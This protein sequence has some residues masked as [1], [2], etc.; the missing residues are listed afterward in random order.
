MGWGEGTVMSVAFGGPV[1]A[2]C[3]DCGHDIVDGPAIG[4]TLRQHAGAALPIARVA[5]LCRDCFV[6]VSGL[7]GVEPTVGLRFAILA[8]PAFLVD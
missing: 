7:I 8:P 5:L 1:T 3:D 4:A 2:R 6:D